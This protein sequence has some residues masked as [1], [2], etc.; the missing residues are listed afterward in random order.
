MTMNSFRTWITGEKATRKHPTSMTVKHGH[1]EYC[2]VNAWSSLIDLD[3][4]HAKML[5][6]E[7]DKVAV[8]PGYINLLTLALLLAV[9]N[10]DMSFGIRRI[11]PYRKLS[12]KTIADF[13]DGYLLVGHEGHTYGMR[14]TE[15]LALDPS[16]PGEGLVQYE[17]TQAQSREEILRTF[18]HAEIGC[19]CD[20]VHVQVWP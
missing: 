16:E 14:C 7:L 15:Q 6:V 11:W 13:A 10:Q 2:T 20:V 4:C 19:M 5:R 8:N 12:L 9:K 18:M 3:D 17:R 1:Y